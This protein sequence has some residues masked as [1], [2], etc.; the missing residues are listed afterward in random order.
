MYI[1]NFKNRINTTD[2]YSKHSYKETFNTKITNLFT[3]EKYKNI[4]VI[5]NGHRFFTQMPLV[6]CRLRKTKP[7]CAVIGLRAMP[8]RF[9]NALL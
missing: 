4:Y 5:Q 6:M 2:L 3:P 7:G 1:P 8:W 9:G